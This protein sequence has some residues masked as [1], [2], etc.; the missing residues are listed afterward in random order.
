MVSFDSAIED[1]VRWKR[2]N[3]EGETEISATFSKFHSTLAGKFPLRII[4]ET[5]IP[6]RRFEIVYKEPELN[7]ALP[8]TLF[9]QKRPDNIREVPLD[10]IGG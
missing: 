8:L 6:E 9:V 4:L 7:L 5:E 10:L 1:L 2:L 3:H